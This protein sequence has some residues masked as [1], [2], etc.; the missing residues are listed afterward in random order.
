LDAV[1]GSVVSF[2]VK[3]IFKWISGL[4]KLSRKVQ[5]LAEVFPDFPGYDDFIMGCCQAM[6]ALN[7]ISNE[8]DIVGARACMTDAMF[9]MWRE[10]VALAD[11]QG[12][13]VNINHGT[14]L[15]AC[16]IN[17]SIEESQVPSLTSRI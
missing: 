11:S 13:M 14:V 1:F 7:T 6:E 4:P 3:K 16:I 12:H 2:V 8:R 17:V 10:A 15:N 5:K 9:D